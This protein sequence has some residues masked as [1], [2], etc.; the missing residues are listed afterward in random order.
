MWTQFIFRHWKLLGKRKQPLFLK[1]ESSNT[2]MRTKDIGEYFFHTAL[3]G[4][5]LQIKAGCVRRIDF[6]QYTAGRDLDLVEVL[7]GISFNGQVCLQPSGTA[8]QFS[9]WSEMQRIQPGET[10]TYGT[11]AKKM[12]K[13]LASRAVGRAVGA[14]PI[15]MLL[16]CHR[17]LP[18]RGGV[19][20]FRWGRWRKRQ[21]LAWESSGKDAL[22]T[23]CA[24]MPLS[25]QFYLDLT[26]CVG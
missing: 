13:P 11:L 23:I 9:V 1:S 19:G 24:G 10:L 4:L 2:N 14:N 21:L 7:Q 16:P 6:L 25:L 8:F 26:T 17:V 5:H 22:A 20:D 12:G 15:A 18:A 3:G